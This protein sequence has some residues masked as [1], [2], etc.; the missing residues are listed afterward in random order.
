MLEDASLIWA[1]VEMAGLASYLS[2]FVSKGEEETVIV[3]KD[4]VKA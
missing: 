2:H 3:A 1:M 4:V